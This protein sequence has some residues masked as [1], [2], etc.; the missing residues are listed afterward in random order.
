MQRAELGKHGI[1]FGCLGQ[2][3]VI[4]V[5]QLRALQHAMHG[6]T[7]F[8]ANLRRHQV[9]VTRQ[10]F[11]GHA[12][13]RQRAQGGCRRFLRRVEEGHVADQGQRRFIGHAVHGF[14]R[15]HFLD[16]HGHHAQA[17]R[18]ET[19]RGFQHLV[20]QGC[21]ER[22]IHAAQAQMAAGGEDFL[23]G[24][25]ADQ[26]MVIILF[27]NDDGH[28]AAHEIERDFIDFDVIAGQLHF[29]LQFHMVEH[30]AVEQVFEAR[31]VMAVQVSE[32][33]HFI[34][35]L[36]EHIRMAL[37]HDLVLRQGACLVGAEHIHG[38]EVLDRIEALHD[39]FLFRQFYG[40]LGQGAG[41][42]HGQHFRRQAD[43]HGQ[44]KQERFHPVALGPAVDQ[45]HQRRHHEGEADQ[46]PADAV[47]ARFKRG[48]RALGGRHA[49][50]DGA[51][52]R[53]VARG[54]YQ[55]RCRARDHIRAH[56]QQIGQFHGVAAPAV[57]QLG[58]LFHRQGFT[59][60]GGLAD[61]QVFCG[62]QTAIG[63]DHVAGRQHDDVAL[64]QL[65]DRQLDL[66]AIAQH[67]GCIADHGFQALGG[68]VRAAFL[69]EAQ[70]GRQNHHGA[71]DDGGL[72]IFRQ[73]GHNRQHGEQQ[74]ERILVAQ[75]QMLVPGQRFFMLDFIRPRLRADDLRLGIAQAFQARMQAVQGAVQVFMGGG[76][77]LAR[78]V[79]GHGAGRA[80]FQRHGAA[81]EMAGRMA[82]AQE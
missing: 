71:D 25:L 9:V 39:D 57:G 14:V 13:C 74:V 56:E 10:D 64:H 79:V 65:A 28:A 8:A 48:R 68:A 21:I 31:L 22:N 77:Q 34:G 44:G 63:R 75:P 54:Q 29:R 50:G 11:H 51:E 27:G 18:I 2:G 66:L 72:R 69:H 60:H 3:G 47:H 7:H 55:R 5:V 53:A 15:W 17:F 35:R 67:G 12:M 16:G 20:Q 26:L 19:M 38:A 23:D 81:A 52:I 70:Q 40:A 59:R 78:Q 32:L 80:V 61:E 1:V 41:D 45:E 37:E 6:Q 36:A 82:F 33:Q 49:R 46:Q 30:G 4:H 76:Q 42:D 24:A 58:H 73:V 62:K 43:G